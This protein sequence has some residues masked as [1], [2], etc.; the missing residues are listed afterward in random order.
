MRYA[1]ALTALFALTYPLTTANAQN[2]ARY[3]WCAEYGN[4]NGGRN[5]GFETLAQCRAAIS[6]D[7][8]ATCVRLGPSPSDRW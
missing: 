1:L 4:G 2:A 8:R 6:G 3:P 7:N 5:C